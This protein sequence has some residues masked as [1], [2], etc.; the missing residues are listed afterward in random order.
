MSDLRRNRRRSEMPCKCESD[1]PAFAKQHFSGE[2]PRL[3]AQRKNLNNQTGAAAFYS[4]RFCLLKSQ[5][6]G[7]FCEFLFKKF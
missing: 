5:E 7:E 6:G 4:I 3:R 2:R 1:T